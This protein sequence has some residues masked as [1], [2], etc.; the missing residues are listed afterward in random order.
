M[1]ERR[2]FLIENCRVTLT[3]TMRSHEAKGFMFMDTRI[4]LRLGRIAGNLSEGKRCEN[5]RKNK[6]PNFKLHSQ[7]RR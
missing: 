3:I 2:F 7:L 5:V 1:S 4:K 6:L